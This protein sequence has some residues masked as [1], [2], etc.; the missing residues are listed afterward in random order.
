MLLNT[1]NMSDLGIH[2]LLEMFSEYE[3]NLI[4]PGTFLNMF[5]DRFTEFFHKFTTTHHSTVTRLHL[6]CSKPLVWSKIV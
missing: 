5:T 6:D 1:V 3:Y 2:A 4:W